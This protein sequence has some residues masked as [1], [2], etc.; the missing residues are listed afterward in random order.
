MRKAAIVTA[1]LLLIIVAGRGAGSRTVEAAE[2]Q[3]GK[4][5]VVTTLFPLYDWA[6]VVGGERVD[7]TLLL[8][9]G[10]ESHAF[11][12]TPRDIAKMHKADIFIYMGD[13]MEPWVTS[14]VK[15]VSGDS[16]LVIDASE[17]IQ[18]L[19][20]T[21][22]T[23][24]PAH[25]HHQGDSKQRFHG[26][27]DPHIW[28]E[29]N[30]A[31]EMVDTIARGL[32]KKDAAHKER[33]EKRA[34]AYK[35]DLRELDDR[36]EQALAHCRHRTL[37]YGGHFAF[38]YFAKRFNLEVISP[39]RGFAPDAE[40]T[41]REIAQL[42][43]KMKTFNIKYIFYEEGIEP[44]VARVIGQEAGAELLM[45]HGAHNVTKDELSAG[46]TYLSLMTDNL[47]RLKTGL[48]CQ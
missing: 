10:V 4:L 9:P 11:E 15:G 17:G 8:P 14:M 33:Y 34:E 3:S 45:L 35:S 5:Q 48:E 27:V 37:I 25:A 43:Q 2:N 1:L 23:A 13:H 36:F 29:F 18:L 6:K 46:V 40:P 22:E 28:L 12:P 21:D 32:M 24:E 7:V 41:P 20:E 26:D 44:K 42:I 30:N 47:E 16:L 31:Q 38:G 39:Y 19:Q